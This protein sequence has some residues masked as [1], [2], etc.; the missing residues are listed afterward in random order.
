MVF[1]AW[2]GTFTS[3][4]TRKM[5]TM[6]K[7]T[8]TALGCANERSGLDQPFLTVQMAY[9][10]FLFENLIRVYVLCSHVEFLKSGMTRAQDNAIV[11][12]EGLRS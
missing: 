1:R 6:A 9:A 4:R 10:T 11:M 12:W 2:A 8:E 3:V 5:R 7:K